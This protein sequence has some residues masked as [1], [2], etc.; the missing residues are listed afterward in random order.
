MNEYVNKIKKTKCSSLC[1]L[2]LLHSSLAGQQLT[3]TA[4]N[5]GSPIAP[6]ILHPNSSWKTSEFGQITLK[7]SMTTGVKKLPGGRSRYLALFLSSAASATFL[8]ILVA[9]VL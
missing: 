6:L 1:Y 9:C 7:D 2:A 4:F 3:G 8:Y 5:L